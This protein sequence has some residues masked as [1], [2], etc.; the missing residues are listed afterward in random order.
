MGNPNQMHPSSCVS[1]LIMFS[2]LLPSVTALFVTAN[3]TLLAM[4]IEVQVILLR[5]LLRCFLYLLGLC[6][7]ATTKCL[8]SIGKSAVIAN[9]M[10]CQSLLDSMNNLFIPRPPP[11]NYLHSRY[12]SPLHKMICVV[13]YSQFSWAT[14]GGSQSHPENFECPKCNQF[15]SRD[16][17]T[18]SSSEKLLWTKVMNTTEQ[19]VDVVCSNCS[20]QVT[21]CARCNKSYLPTQKSAMRQHTRRSHKKVIPISK[22]L[23]SSTID[24]AAQRDQ[25]LNEPDQNNQDN[26]HWDDCDRAEHMASYIAN[27][28]VDFG[29]VGSFSC[30]SDDCDVMSLDCSLS[31]DF[32]N[33]FTEN[34]AEY[35]ATDHVQDADFDVNDGMNDNVEDVFDDSGKQHNSPTEPS[36]IAYSEENAMGTAA[37]EFV[38][39]LIHFDIDPDR[40]NTDDEEDC[41]S[42]SGTHSQS[43]TEFDENA[44]SIDGGPTDTPDNGHYSYSDFEYFDTREEVD[45]LVRKGKR[46]KKNVRPNCIS[47]KSIK[48]N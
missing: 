48:P 19:W 12:L 44:T 32:H 41:P 23:P 27:N 9:G 35:T 24:A 38:E 46:R 39:R 37:D 45:K 1:F 13:W 4:V 34:D 6:V 11:E 29:S 22:P 17:S 10:L 43:S 47:G 15:S 36:T 40:D 33:E 2:V 3:A 30:K 28:D 42:L 31:F 16:D 5:G 7:F 25:G 14:S 18:H 20:L 8:S 21:Q 26:S